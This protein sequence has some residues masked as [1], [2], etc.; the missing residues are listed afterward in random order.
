MPI[1]RCSVKKTSIEGSAKVLFP[2][3]EERGSREGGC[4]LDFRRGFYRNLCESGFRH[5]ERSVAICKNAASGERIA[6]FQR[7]DA[8]F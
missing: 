7:N 2:L 5:C 3:L 8:V 1:R 6:S 4:L